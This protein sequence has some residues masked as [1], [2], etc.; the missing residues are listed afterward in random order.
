MWKTTTTTM[1]APKPKE[2]LLVS[3]YEPHIKTLQLIAEDTTIPEYKTN[4]TNECNELLD[5]IYSNV[6]AHTVTTPGIFFFK[7]S[8][9]IYV[10]FDESIYSLEPAYLYHNNDVKTYI[11]ALNNNNKDLIQNYLQLKALL[12]TKVAQHMETREKIIELLLFMQYSVGQSIEVP[13]Y[14][15]RICKYLGYKQQLKSKE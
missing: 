11:D 15:K 13:N 9:T 4:K 5:Q 1:P 14:N 8:K 10:K 7:T 12:R 3:D 2:T 6:G